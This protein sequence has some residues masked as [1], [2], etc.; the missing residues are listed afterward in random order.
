MS[1]EITTAQRAFLRS[2]ARNSKPDVNIGKSGITASSLEHIGGILQRR[3]LVKLHLLESA[4]TDR[5]QAAQELA[6][7]LNAFLVDVVGRA[8]VL[9]RPNPELPDHQRLQLPEK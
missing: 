4:S 6:R 5:K 7:S 3:E 1:I 8:V 2:I 9:Y